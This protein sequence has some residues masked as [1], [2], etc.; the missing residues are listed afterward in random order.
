MQ[1]AIADA[2]ANAYSDAVSNAEAALIAKNN[3]ELAK[4]EKS[5]W[6]LFRC[7][8]ELD[9][10]KSVFEELQLVKVYDLFNQVLAEVEETVQY[11]KTDLNQTASTY[12]VV[13]A[14]QLAE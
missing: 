8:L 12:K 6:G 2:K 11:D 3:E 4:L 13:T 10:T 14:S 5:I 7:I 1:L 9:T